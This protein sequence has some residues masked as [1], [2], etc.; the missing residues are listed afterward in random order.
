LTFVGSVTANSPVSLAFEPSG[1]FLYAADA[2]LGEIDRFRIRADGTLTFVA[3]ADAGSRAGALAVHPSGRFLYC[4]DAG[5]ARVLAY[6]LDAATGGLTAA[7]FFT[8]SVWI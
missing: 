1:R 5:S 7:G 3:R 4:L 8:L 2:G 6:R